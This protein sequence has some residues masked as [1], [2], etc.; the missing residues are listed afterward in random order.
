MKKNITWNIVIFILVL[1]SGCAKP[2]EPTIM[3]GAL[4]LDHFY[5]TI[6]YVRDIVV[7]DSL[8]FTA[9]DQG[10]FS[11]FNHKTNQQMSHYEESI[12]NARLICLVEE[13]NTLILYDR[14]GSPPQILLYDVS[15]AGNPTYLNQI[16]GNSAGIEAML[17]S[18]NQG[19]VDMAYIRNETAHEFIHGN[20]N[21]EY[22]NPYVLYNFEHTLYG[23]DMDE[24]FIYLAYQ[25][26]GL[27]I[28]DINTGLEV[29]LTDTD[30]DAR[31]V[32]IVDN[33]AFISDRQEGFTILDISDVSNP[34]FVSQKDTDG[35]TRNIDVEGNYMV[36][37]SGGGGVYLYDISNIDDPEFL[38]RVDDSEIGYTYKTL[39]KDGIIFVATRR[40]VAK[41][42]I[43]L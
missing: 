39:I 34:T 43:E 30:G 10:G 29:S 37:A 40:G 19:T 12:D 6:G 14:Y 9:E 11:I 7:T 41:F 18:D 23:F 33:Y 15:D 42:S 27:N 13:T 38:D 26:L 22:F 31:N 8:L 25:Q 1:F 36:V 17:C 24:N 28:V 5:S 20:Y 35:F 21:G 16:I 4:K 2:N 32:T 3:D